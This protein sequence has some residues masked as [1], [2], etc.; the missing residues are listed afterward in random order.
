MDWFEGVGGGQFDHELHRGLILRVPKHPWKYI[1]CIKEKKKE[2]KRKQGKGRERKGKEGK[3]GERR[4][5]KGKE[6]KRKQGKGRERREN[7]KGER[8]ERERSGA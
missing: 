4:G 6:G 2:G 8:K 7:G 3:E 5:K 1:E